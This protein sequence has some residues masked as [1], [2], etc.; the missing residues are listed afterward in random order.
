MTRLVCVNAHDRCYGGAGG[1]CPYCEPA[2]RS[3][4]ACPK[5]QRIKSSPLTDSAEGQSCTLR[6][7]PNCGDGGVV[8]CHHRGKG[9]GTG[10]KPPDF[11]GFYGCGPCHMA[12]EAGLV[13]VAEV[14]RAIRETQERMA[15]A[16]LLTVK[17]WKP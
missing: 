7:E 16:G 14:A 11:W 15:M 12:E 17:G 1:P 4:A 8:F 10:T 6:W 9:D 3:A 2:R 13:P 5:P